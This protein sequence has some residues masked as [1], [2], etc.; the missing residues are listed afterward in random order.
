MTHFVLVRE[1][2]TFGL[3]VNGELAEK[4]E[5]VPDVD[6]RNMDLSPGEV[7]RMAYRKPYY[8][9]HTFLEFGRS[10]YSIQDKD[11]GYVFENIQFNPMGF[12]EYHMTL[13]L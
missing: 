5:V 10:S 7:Y 4:A 8:M 1:N 9:A 2:D 13:T 11:P 12:Q 3:I 6:T